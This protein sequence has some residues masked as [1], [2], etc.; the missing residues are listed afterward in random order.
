MPANVICITN[1]H[2]CSPSGR[3]FLEQLEK[4]AQAGPR[5]I[6]L[7]EKDLDEEF[8]KTRETLASQIQEELS[9]KEDF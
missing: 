5:Q 4:I 6:I 7:R 1:R 9:R 8:Q 3:S 2:L